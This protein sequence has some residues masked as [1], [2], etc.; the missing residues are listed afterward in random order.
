MGSEDAIRQTHV[1]QIATHG[2]DPRIDRDRT[3]L[4]GEALTRWPGGRRGD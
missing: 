1:R 4:E 3:S 2:I